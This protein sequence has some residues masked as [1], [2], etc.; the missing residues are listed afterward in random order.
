M[1]I[2]DICGQD[3]LL[4]CS[5][6]SQPYSFH[7]DGVNVAYADGSVHF[8]SQEIDPDA[9]VSLVTLAAGD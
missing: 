3:Q 6:N 5:N 2:N 9:F 8:V 1:T 4:N 7:V